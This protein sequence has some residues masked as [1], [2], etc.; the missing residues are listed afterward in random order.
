MQEKNMT[1]TESMQLITS[2]INKAKNSFT[3][4]G[5]FYLLWGWLIFTCCIIQF[6]GLHFFGYEKVYFVWYTTWVLLVYQFIYFAGKKKAHKVRMYTSE[7]IKYV[8]IVYVIT[9]ALL[10][11]ILIYNKAYS[12]L[13]PAI[14]ATYGMPTFLVGVIL[15]FNPLKIGG[16]CCWL[17]AIAAPFVNYDYQFLLIASAVII[18][19]VIPGYRFKQ[20]FKNSN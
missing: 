10:I 5:T 17:L 20:N 2:M 14:L 13:N 18:A 6:V 9:Y 3:E 7:I 15:K 19:W 1:E 12:S 8:W 4:S 11:F 16:I